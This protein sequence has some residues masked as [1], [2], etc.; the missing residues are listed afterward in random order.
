[1]EKTESTVNARRKILNVAVSAI[2]IETGFES[3]DKQALETMSEMLQSCK[4]PQ[5]CFIHINDV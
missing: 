5:H 3:A 4:F 1:M 2:L